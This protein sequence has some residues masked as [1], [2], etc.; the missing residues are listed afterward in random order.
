MAF[1]N[2]LAHPLMANA[3]TIRSR[4]RGIKSKEI[5]P[6]RP[7]LYLKLHNCS[8]KALPYRNRTTAATKLCP[9]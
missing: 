7:T 4:P 6:S 8:H 3:S 1:V 9:N 5:K 2:I